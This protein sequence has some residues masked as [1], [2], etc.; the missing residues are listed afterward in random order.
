MPTRAAID[1]RVRKCASSPRRAS[2]NGGRVQSSTSAQVATLL[3][4]VVGES[5]GPEGGHHWNPG[6][7]VEVPLEVWLAGV[8]RAPALLEWWLEN[9]MVSADKQVETDR[10]PAP[11]MPSR[12]TGSV[13]GS[14]MGTGRTPSAIQF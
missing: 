6:E 10:G 1:R 4:R 9:P 3:G 8:H 5:D 11:G 12:K 7:D 14:T 2:R 13:S